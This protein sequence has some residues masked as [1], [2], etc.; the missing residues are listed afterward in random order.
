MKILYVA[1]DQRVPGTTGGSVHVRSVADGLAALGHDVDVLTTPGDGPFPAGQVQ[2]HA[3]SPPFGM[4]HLRGLRAAAVAR[5]AYR[6]GAEV[7]IERYH[8]F[9][10]EGIR[11]ADATDALAVLEVNAPVI[12]YPGSPKAWFDR[13]LVVEPMRRWREWQCRRADLVI[14]PTAAIIPAFVPPDR[15]VEIEWGADT[16]SFRPGAEGQLPFTREPGAVLA[17]FAGAFRAWHGAINLVR[18]V[19]ALR[20]RGRSG[21]QAVLIGD[22]PEWPRVKEEASHVP[23]ITLTGAV[24]HDQMPAC[25]AAADIG[26]AP[27]DL[28]AH[29]PLQLAFY[30]SPLKVFEYMAAGLP[31]VAPAIPRLASIVR[32]HQEGLLYNPREPGGLAEALGRLVDDAALRRTLGAAARE[33]V[34]T[35]FSWKAHC[36]RLDKAL[37]AALDARVASGQGPGARHTS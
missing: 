19:R 2:W 26:V 14:T 1:L 27:F 35:S 37:T 16:E 13:L 9:G 30:W 34:A 3:M 23:G 29:P 12:D 24:P 6:V 10:G 22:G 5:M 7:V 11:A 21:L 25:L 36:T 17:V 20:A 15:I 18:A 28:E 4:R 32:S 8:N 33:R 31:V